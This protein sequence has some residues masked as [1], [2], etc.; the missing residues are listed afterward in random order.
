MSINDIHILSHSK[1]N[2]KKNEVHAGNDEESEGDRLHPHQE[3]DDEE[4]VFPL[5]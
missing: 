4:D 1:W 5:L 3:N 2:C